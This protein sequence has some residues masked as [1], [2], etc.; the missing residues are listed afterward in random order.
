MLEPSEGVVDAD[1]LLLRLRQMTDIHQE[2]IRMSSRLNS[3]QRAALEAYI[4]EVRSGQATS[5]DWEDLVYLMNGDNIALFEGTLQM[6]M[7]TKGGRNNNDGDIIFGGEMDD[8][9]SIGS[10]DLGQSNQVKSSEVLDSPTRVRAYAASI[11]DRV[12]KKEAKRTVPMTT[13]F[14][15][16]DD[17]DDIPSMVHE[18]GETAFDGGRS[19][20]ASNGKVPFQE[21]ESA[22]ALDSIFTGPAEAVTVLILRLVLLMIWLLAFGEE[23]P[24]KSESQSGN[25]IDH[26]DPMANSDV[27]LA[28]TYEDDASKAQYAIPNDTDEDAMFSVPVHDIIAKAAAENSDEGPSGSISCMVIE[29]EFD[30]KLLEEAERLPELLDRQSALHDLQQKQDESQPPSPRSAEEL[31][32]LDR[33]TNDKTEDAY[34][35]EKSKYDTLTDASPL[36]KLLKTNHMSSDDEFD[37]FLK[38]EA[39]MTKANTALASARNK[40]VTHFDVAQNLYNAT[41]YVWSWGKTKLLKTN[42]MSSNDEFDEFLKFE[43]VM[44][45]AN[46][47]LRSSSRNKDVADFDLFDTTKYLCCS[48]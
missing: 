43:A 32:R 21:N 26:I 39:V 20:N 13:K 10:V 6:V 7:Q 36:V 48:L 28:M 34:Q 16:P 17:D 29:N 38:F 1:N 24:A 27:D 3:I 33:S 14:D 15:P 40:D 23:S 30:T 8:N 12:H 44:T 46:A 11:L 19:E 47:A 22:S 18:V 45:K 35:N 25:E 31:L 42:E 41:K 37:E 9:T 5:N 4:V 2:D